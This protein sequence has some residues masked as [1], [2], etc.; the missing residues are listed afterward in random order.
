MVNFPISEIAWRGAAK[1]VFFAA[2]FLLAMDI[3]DGFAG[4]GL[5]LY[6]P[7]TLLAGLL[8]AALLTS[9]AL[10]LLKITQLVCSK[11]IFD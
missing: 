8:L 11:R 2:F 7:F 6:A 10:V 3:F 9:G 5:W 1:A 4:K